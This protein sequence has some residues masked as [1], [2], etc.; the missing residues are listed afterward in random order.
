MRTN[1][2]DAED[3]EDA[4]HGN[5]DRTVRGGI[6]GKSEGI[7]AI[8]LKWNHEIFRRVPFTVFVE[9]VF[10]DEPGRVP[11]A[12]H[13]KHEY[14]DLGNRGAFASLTLTLCL[15]VRC[16]GQTRRSG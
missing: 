14:D 9:S 3:V 2:K 12:G 11:D 4:K 6:D 1:E 13:V 15:R 7:K 16:T 5:R 8:V 10:R